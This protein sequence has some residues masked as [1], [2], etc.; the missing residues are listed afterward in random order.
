[1]FSLKRSGSGSPKAEARERDAKA[2][3][4]LIPKNDR[5][6]EGFSVSERVQLYPAMLGYEERALPAFLAEKAAALKG[7]FVELG[8]YLGGSTVALLDGLAKASALKNRR[9]PLIHS[10]DLFIAN[11]YM[12]E[13]A[14]K[15]LNLKA[16]E[17]FLQAFL[18][19][20]GDDARYVQV[21]P[22]DI[23][24]QQW[25][26]EPIALLYVDILWGW[27]INRWVIDQ[28]YRSLRKGSWIIHQDFVFPYYPWLP[29]SMEWFVRNGYF[30]VTSFAE[31]ST[32]AFQC[33]K[34][35]DA[36]ACE[37]DFL[38]QLGL[39]EKR[40]LLQTSAERFIGY[41]K[42]L[43]ELS[44][45]LLLADNGQL[46]E[47]IAQVKTIRS[48]YDDRFGH[49]AAMEKTLIGRQKDV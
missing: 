22:G 25:S 11:D 5:T 7:E 43:L 3:D 13:H 26:G 38:V 37:F 12:V 15:H 46:A 17:S 44:E 23:R 48:N 9:R 4:L 33:E 41:P 18:S 1:M 29:I 21:Y 36:A 32:I 30:S 24:K 14:P 27:D 45:C 2:D 34:Q 10:Y 49:A 40:Q 35:L 6:Y 20:L 39:A 47:A 19:L 16:G 8:C 28:F 42:A 31:F